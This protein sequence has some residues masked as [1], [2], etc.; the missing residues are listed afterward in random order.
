V[1]YTLPKTLLSSLI[2]FLVSHSEQ[3]IDSISSIAN[4]TLLLLKSLFQLLL[5]F[6]ALI[7]TG[8]EFA[9]EMDKAAALLDFAMTTTC[10]PMTVVVLLSLLLEDVFSLM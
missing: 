5:S 4:D 7:L 10:A 1:E 2:Q 3:H 9:K 6:S 8:V